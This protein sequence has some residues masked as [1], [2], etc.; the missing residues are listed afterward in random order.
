MNKFKVYKFIVKKKKI[1]K[2]NK[3]TPSLDIG[4]QVGG[5]TVLVCMIRFWCK[6]TACLCLIYVSKSVKGLV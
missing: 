1:K 6:I 2:K 5:V 4:G 3:M